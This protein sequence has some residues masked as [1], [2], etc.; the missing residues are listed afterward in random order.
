M[1]RRF[2]EVIERFV[3]AQGCERLVDF[4][5]GNMPYR[6]MFEAHVDRY[7]GVDLSGNEMADL[8][9]RGPDEIPLPGISHM[10]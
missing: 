1:R 6:P 9:V 2:E 7:I 8:T 4:G 5:C 10:G 3:V